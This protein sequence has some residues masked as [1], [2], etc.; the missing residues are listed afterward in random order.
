MPRAGAAPWINIANETY[1][2]DWKKMI[3]NESSHDVIFK[4]KSSQFYAHK[5]HLCSSSLL[6]RRVFQLESPIGH[7]DINEGMIQGLRYIKVGDITE[8]GI[9]EAISE[10]IFL[11]ILEFLYTG[12]CVIHNKKVG[13]FSEISLRCK[14]MVSETVIAAEMFGCEELVTICQNILDENEDLNPSFS[15]YLSDQ[16][17]EISTKFPHFLFFQEAHVENIS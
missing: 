3:N 5:I 9:S 10:T 7:G 17:G 8:I 6:F 4:L 13:N 11:R 12:F 1:G 2:D 15:T 14:D 16:S